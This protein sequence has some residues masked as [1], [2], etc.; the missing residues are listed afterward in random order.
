MPK[1]KHVTA[2]ALIRQ[3]QQSI[4]LAIRKWYYLG[5]EGHALS[6]RGTGETAPIIRRSLR[7]SGEVAAT[8]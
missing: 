8:V 2:I 7:R 1:R 4:E 5:R 6:W 3:A